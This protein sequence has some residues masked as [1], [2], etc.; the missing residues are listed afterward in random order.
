MTLIERR[1]AE[2]GAASAIRRVRLGGVPVD[3]CSLDE[4]VELVSRRAT[5][6]GDRPLAVVSVNLDHL[7]HFGDGRALNG[8]FG[9]REGR[10][11]AIE[12]LHLIDGAP[13][14][15]H[16][17]RLTGR[18]HPRLAGSDLIAPVLERAEREGAAIG[19]LG[20][21][22]DTHAA[23]S[24]S[25]REHYPRLRVA[26]LWAPDRADLL[27]ADR[28]ADLAAEIAAAQ[29]S[30]LV[31]CLG[32]PRQELWIDRFGAETG[33]N[34]LLAFGA[35]VDFLAGRVSRAPTWVADAGLEWAWRLALEPR[36]LFRRYVVQGP[37]AYAMLRRAG[38]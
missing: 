7:H 8:A 19:F 12:W 31:V 32:K 11:S 26:G 38:T 10:R 28:S 34:V 6:G 20:G 23:L 24:E 37:G 35:V 25:L 29:V 27:D 2:P 4:A 13:I 5:S 21:S 36:R 16:A 15:A 3:L 17:Q 18:P 30:V 9:L 1:E 22:P 14:A 33:A